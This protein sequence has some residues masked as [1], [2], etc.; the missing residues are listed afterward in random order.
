MTKFTTCLLLTLSLSALAQRGEEHPC[1]EFDQNLAQADR[2]VREFD[3][4]MRK[5]DSKLRNIQERLSARTQNLND[6]IQQSNSLSAQLSQLN[7]ERMSAS[8]EENRLRAEQAVVSNQIAQQEQLRRHY[9][10]QANATRDLAQKREL[11]RLGKQTELEVG[12]L[13]GQLN[14]INMGISAAAAQSTNAERQIRSSNNQL[15]ELN[16]R[17]S[18]ER[19][20]PQL[21][22][23]Q[24][25]MAQAEMELTNAN[26]GL[27]QQQRQLA[28]AQSH[29][30]MCYGYQ[31]LSVKYPSALHFSRRINAVGCN[32]YAPVNVRNELEAQAQADVLSSMCNR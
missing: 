23:M 13:Q 19:N 16:A 5:L 18:Q 7:R 10:A 27:E 9:Q 32:R 24:Q 31:E 25:D 21:R 30:E 2:Q 17:I 4:E 28:R 1:F 14:A 6:L 26:Q 11:L 15:A 20:D 3:R 12:R 8:Q 22:R 29:V